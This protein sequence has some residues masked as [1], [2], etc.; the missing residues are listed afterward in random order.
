VS[1]GNSILAVLDVY[2]G[3][4][5]GVYSGIAEYHINSSPSGHSRGAVEYVR[6]YILLNITPKV[7]L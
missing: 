4:C 6:M 5:C 1:G 7:M 3:R 2:S